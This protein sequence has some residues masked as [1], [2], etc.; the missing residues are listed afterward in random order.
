M[1]SEPVLNSGKPGQGRAVVDQASGR[2]RAKYLDPA[3]L[4]HI[5]SLEVVARQVVEGV[6]IGH[7]KS[8]ARGEQLGF[9]TAW[10]HIGDLLPAVERIE[11]VPFGLRKGRARHSDG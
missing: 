4:S 10:R 11:L 7:H 5:G 8:P 6:R 2:S 1:N 9:L 3:T